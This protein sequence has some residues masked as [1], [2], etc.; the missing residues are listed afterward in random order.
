MQN[1]AAKK[2]AANSGFQGSATE[3]LGV[4]SQWIETPVPV[5]E[6]ETDLLA[7]LFDGGIASMVAFK[8]ISSY[9]VYI[10]SRVP[11]HFE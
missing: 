11:S 1:P 6:H 7:S 5:L 3:Y 8:N 10:R 2:L 4:P 9:L